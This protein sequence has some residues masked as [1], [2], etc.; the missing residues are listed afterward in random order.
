VLIRVRRI[1]GQLGALE[2]A[3]ESGADCGPV[4]Q[5]IAAVRGAVNGLMRQ[6]LESHIQE[7]LGAPDVT[8]SQRRQSVDQLNELLRTYLK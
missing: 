7:T 8:D 6:V 2:T 4:L 3:L 1:K 5:Q